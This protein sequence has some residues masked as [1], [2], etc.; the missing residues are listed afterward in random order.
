MR[1]KLTPEELEELGKRIAE[2]EAESRR[3]Q[4]EL[5]PLRGEWCAHTHL[6][7]QQSGSEGYLPRE[8]RT[9]VRTSRGLSVNGT[10]LTLY[11]IRD[12]LKGED[13]LKNIRDFFNL[14]DE[15]MLEILDYMYLNKEEFEKE[16]QK[17]LELAAEHRKYWEEKNRDLME[18][19][20]ESREAKMV[21]LREW[22]EKYQAKGKHEDAAGS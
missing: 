14:T 20:R 3:I 11:D 15:E 2:L 17:I 5:A 7:K 1:D 13:S 16:Y 10:R 21:R 8:N 18:K 12:Y 6:K 9:V 4:K 22:S 19:T